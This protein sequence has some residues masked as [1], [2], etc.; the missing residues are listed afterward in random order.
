[1][2]K[3]LPE[4]QH[5][6]QTTGF[7]LDQQRKKLVRDPEPAHL[8]KVLAA[9]PG[10][11][12]GNI[13]RHSFFFSLLQLLSLLNSVH[14][15]PARAVF[16]SPESDKPFEPITSQKMSVDTS[17][18]KGKYSLPGSKII[19][20][21]VIQQH[22]NYSYLSEKENIHS[23][24][25]LPKENNTS[26]SSSM[27][28]I[29]EKVTAVYSH[30][31]YN[32]EWSYKINYADI[33]KTA[34]GYKNYLSFSER[35]VPASIEIT[36]NELSKKSLHNREP[37][38]FVIPVFHY[39]ANELSFRN[40]AKRSLSEV[41]RNIGEAIHNP[42]MAMSTHIYFA[43][44]EGAVNEEEMQDLT[45]RAQLSDYELDI[46]FLFIPFG[47]YIMITRGIA[48]SLFKITADMLDGNDGKIEDKHNVIE[49]LKYYVGLVTTKKNF[50]PPTKTNQIHQKISDN[51]YNTYKFSNVK[52]FSEKRSLK[53]NKH[54]VPSQKKVILEKK[55][56][57]IL[58]D[59]SEIKKKEVI[60]SAPDRFGM[61]NYVN[62]IG[63]KNSKLIKINKK[64]YPVVPGRKKNTFYLN[65]RKNLKMRLFNDGYHIVKKNKSR[66]R[67]LLCIKKTFRSL[68]CASL[69]EKL[70][71]ALYLN[72]GRA[73]SEKEVGPLSSI[74]YYSAIYRNRKGELYIRFKSHYFPLKKLTKR[75]TGKFYSVLAKEN[76]KKVY[77]DIIKRE[78]RIIEVSVSHLKGRGHLNT[79]EENM[80]ESAG[81][82]EDM[83]VKYQASIRISHEMNQQSDDI[84]P[85][86]RFDD[87]P[88]NKAF[89]KIAGISDENVDVGYRKIENSNYLLYYTKFRYAD[90][91]YEEQS[92]SLVISSHAGYIDSDTT[93]PPVILPSDITIKLL[94]P[95]DTYL[96]DP[97][98]DKVINTSIEPY[99]TIKDNE[100]INVNFLPQKHDEWLES[101]D[102]NP[103]SKQNIFGRK[104]GL[105][106]YRHY[107]FED[108]TEEVA[109]KVLLKNRA[110][111]AEGKAELTD[112]LLMDDVISR[113]DNTEPELAS[114][115]KVIEL[116]KEGRLVNAKGQRYKNIIF[117]HCRI[118]LLRTTPSTYILNLPDAETSLDEGT[119][120]EA[121]TL[122][123]L[124]RQEDGT[125]FEL[126]SEQSGRILLRQLRS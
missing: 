23:A 90:E 94:T 120:S 84:V 71:R 21:S 125:T 11:H 112:I 8:I 31:K 12:S 40:V 50:Q 48:G 7:F 22:I 121:L 43:N 5:H 105:Q 116:D 69:S 85:L 110:L 65:E 81:I 35:I 56:I 73:F 83:A 102:Y 59:L 117:S 54:T 24:S 98:L 58:A 115:Q 55:Q 88:A 109:T 39:N 79:P 106:N 77:M 126:V 107:Q 97:G 96:E 122:S 95:H 114:I 20:P 49:Q 78:E 46:I 41:L 113:P 1:M 19:I 33:S 111:A 93:S 76:K 6:R 30:V 37:H 119:D 60:I 104:D 38:T 124:R 61:Y 63:K 9:R 34:D 91:A 92:N 87:V 17:V 28:G 68:P 25:A 103:M 108:D 64:F 26:S 16:L 89:V 15:T 57:D 123:L 74:D 67:Y 100:I 45:F 51:L 29:A 13:S 18:G 72:Q 75:K 70:H 47:Q 36:K 3:L 32:T 2:S 66:L 10:L 82:A 80:M 52:S 118:N 4:Y 42:V 99:V 53:L 27:I 14:N 101:A 86:V 62:K 44:L